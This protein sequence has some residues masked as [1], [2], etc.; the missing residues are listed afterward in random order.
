ML[1]AHGSP[2][3]DRRCRRWSVGAPG[4]YFANAIG[5]SAAYCG[6]E[7]GEYAVLG[8]LEVALGDAHMC[9]AY[10]T[11]TARAAKAVEKKGVGHTW[12][13]GCA[14]NIVLPVTPV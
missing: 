12:A 5:K 7:S 6:F 1:A 11:A 10:S 2:P 9:K 3:S 4:L 13:V 8:L 14:K